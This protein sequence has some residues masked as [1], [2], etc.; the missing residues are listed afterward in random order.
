MQFES[1]VIC[2]GLWCFCSA[3]HEKKD[4][5]RII[6][7]K[8]SLSFSTFDHSVPISVQTDKGTETFTETVPEHIQQPLIETICKELQ[9]S[10]KCPSTGKSAARTTWVIDQIL[11]TTEKAG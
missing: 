3:E 8:G 5:I 11:N 10:G 9:G 1:G 6:G 7:T 4:I 2:N